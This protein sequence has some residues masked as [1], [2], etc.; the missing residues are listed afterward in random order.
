M[1]S[2]TTVEEMFVSVY[3]NDMARAVAFYETALGATV[4]LA[5]PTWSALVIAGIRVSL[6][7]RE[8][9]PA[10]SGLHFIVDDVAL[11]CAAVAC[12]GGQIAPA[13]EASHG[14]VIAEVLDTEG[15]TFTLRQRRARTNEEPVHAASSAAPAAPASPHAA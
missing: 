8:H 14:I 3:V 7:L 5:S 9:E 11:A 13:V 10:S 6:V 4:D 12:A 2:M 15:N 1:H